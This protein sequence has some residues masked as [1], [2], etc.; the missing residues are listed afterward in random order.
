M[1][2]Q[3]RWRDAMI[4]ALVFAL[5]GL[6]WVIFAPTRFGGQVAYIL[7]NGSSMEPMFLRGDLVIVRHAVEYAPG[8]AIAYRNGDLG[9]VVFHRIVELAQDRF[10]LKGDNNDWLDHY[11]PVEQEILGKQWLHVPGAGDLVK[12]LRS[13][14]VMAFFAAIIGVMLMTINS[15]NQNQGASQRSFRFDFPDL[16]VRGLSQGAE[17]AIFI[18]GMIFF[19]ALFL[20]IFSFT[21]PVHRLTADN[22]EFVQMGTYEYRAAAPEGIYDGP[23]LSGEP[24]FQ[25]LSDEVAL[26]FLYH[27]VTERPHD[28]VGNYAVQAELSDVSGLKRTIP[29]VPTTAFEGD[30]F[31][32]SAIINLPQL[33]SLVENIEEQTGLDRAQ[34]TLSIVPTIHILGNIQ[35]R[36]LEETFSPILRFYLDDIM[37]QVARTEADE[38]PFQISQPG[39]VEGTRLV[40]ATL[41]IFG[42]EMPV[43]TARTLSGV[44]LGLS[45]L[46]G[47]VLYLL[48]HQVTKGE[49]T[50]LIALKYAPL[51][52][53]VTG[54]NLDSRG[55]VVDVNSIEDLVRLAERHGET[56]LHE[57]LGN[58]HSYYLSHDNHIFRYQMSANM[59]VQRGGGLVSWK[60]ELQTA[61]EREEFEIYYQPV[62]SL[63]NNKLIMVEAL[64]R[65]RHPEKGL[66]SPAEFLPAAE[67]TGMIVPIG[68]WVLKTTCAQLRAWREPG[69]PQISLALNL[70]ISQLQ[71][72]NLSELVSKN[73][74]EAGLEPGDIRLEF[75]ASKVLSG[76]EQLSPRLAELQQLGVQVWVDDFE[77]NISLNLLTSLP[78]AGLKIEG[79]FS[80][81]VIGGT[82]EGAVAR[83]L[84][85]LAHNMNMRVVAEGIEEVDQADFFRAQNCDE[86]Q[87]FLFGRPMSR[88]EL[89]ALLHES[90]EVPL[91]R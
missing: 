55:Q 12:K 1:R 37:L 9:Q 63:E 13:P 59:L 43:S 25:K 36:A 53:D 47:L 71:K 85:E 10:I 73:L 35:D 60:S 41:S 67:E 79:G 22:F 61:L 18:L 84:I 30:H 5:L 32:A 75:S 38:N 28:L 34:Y 83:A 29:L 52:A 19:V 33:Q 86:G 70:S 23:E 51:L 68:E 57:S 11:Q 4:S 82:N 27:F 80:R 3:T 88:H 65:W 26:M 78:V 62:F 16:S 6:L 8:D 42:L 91:D 76:M 66:I 14:A 31:T 20:G 87:G 21:R 54:T 50:A 89:E 90:I 56:I 44:G 24:V 17:I 45:I 64:L 7:V 39:L 15:R 40:P 58:M 69:L 81:R 48:V 49:E 46:G 72:N 74:E 77:S 2:T